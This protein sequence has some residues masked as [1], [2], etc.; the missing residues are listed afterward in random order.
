MTEEYDYPP[1]NEMLDFLRPRCRSL[2][3]HIRFLGA[4]DPG[5]R[6]I[7]RVHLIYRIY[8]EKEEHNGKSDL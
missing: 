5:A 7:D 8:K 1:L 4:L 6:I 3:A 2:L